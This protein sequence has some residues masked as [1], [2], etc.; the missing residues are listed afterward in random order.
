MWRGV[1]GAW[2]GID[3]HVALVREGF[4]TALRMPTGVLRL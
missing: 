2:I 4:Q 3:Q 1:K